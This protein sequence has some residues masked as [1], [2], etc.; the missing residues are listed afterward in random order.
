MERKAKDSPQDE[1][2][3]EEAAWL[4]EARAREQASSTSEEGS[5]DLEKVEPGPQPQGGTLTGSASAA[6]PS[7]Q[8]TATQWVEKD[9]RKLGNC[10]MGLVH[11]YSGCGM[12]MLAPEPGSR[13]EV[14]ARRTAML[15]LPPA[16][17]G[18]DAPWGPLPGLGAVVGFTEVPGNARVVCG[19]VDE[20]G[21]GTRLKLVGF[22]FELQE[23]V[24]AVRAA[25]RRGVRVKILLDN[26]VGSPPVGTTSVQNRRV[27]VLLRAGAEVRW[28]VRGIGQDR[29]EDRHRDLGVLPSRARDYQGARAVWSDRRAFI[30][31]ACHR[32]CTGGDCDL[33]VELRLNSAGREDLD[34]WWSRIWTVSRLAQVTGGPEVGEAPE[35]FLSPP[36]ETLTF[37]SG[38]QP[39]LESYRPHP[40]SWE[41]RRQRQWETVS[42]PGL[43]GALAVRPFPVVEVRPR[44]PPG[45]TLHE[46][47]RASTE[48]QLDLAVQNRVDR[49]VRR[50]QSPT[51][52]ARGGKAKGKGQNHQSC[53]R[54]EVG[55]PGVPGLARARRGPGEPGGT[56]RDA[57]RQA[58]EDAWEAECRRSREASEELRT[59]R[60]RA[61]TAR[62]E[63]QVEPRGPREVCREIALPRERGQEPAEIPTPLVVGG[64]APAGP[65]S[66][67]AGE[68][69][70]SVQ[71]P[72]RSLPATEWELH[73]RELAGW[74]GRAFTAP[75][76]QEMASWEPPMRGA[77]V[78]AELGEARQSLE[79][80]REERDQGLC[81]EA[82]L[83]WAEERVRRAERAAETSGGPQ[84][85]ELDPG[86][87]AAGVAGPPAAGPAGS[88]MHQ[89]VAAKVRAMKDSME[90]WDPYELK[91][92]GV[93][94]S[95]QKG[96]LGPRVEETTEGAAG[97]G[98][99]SRQAQ[100]YALLRALQEPERTV[101]VEPSGG[102][103]ESGAEAGGAVVGGVLAPHHESRASA[104]D[105]RAW[106]PG[107]SGLRP[108]AVGP[109]EYQDQAGPAAC[110]QGNQS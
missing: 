42:V 91:T 46:G 1:A 101:P 43:P 96:G 81:D 37:G 20:T 25:S 56:A 26:Q 84:E 92:S 51:W 58:R 70:R 30:G 13:S 106:Q 67:P 27:D 102:S 80:L 31:A 32:R 65:G 29:G 57:A 36:A 62:T 49:A 39:E 64:D 103:M 76:E 71:D 38:M 6:G 107:L 77:M 40:M 78:A 2:S 74:S 8:D 47:G 54:E 109:R 33:G 16:G 50:V 19:I 17:P 48:V 45:E 89:E 35:V 73:V 24:D 75:T 52:V 94:E 34:A 68:E 53:S 86:K 15:H 72:M 98:V 88:A 14:E 23:V 95:G 104:R 21:A 22:T 55:T 90:D 93:Q 79:A 44:R 105:S 110:A 12:R 97:P 108:V 18:D 10:S 69:R 99:S 61:W 85:G 11:A 59:Q 9:W 5:E 100:V 41:A 63:A 3:E 7:K 60:L 87:Q 66:R 82:V 28:A 4:R 83:A